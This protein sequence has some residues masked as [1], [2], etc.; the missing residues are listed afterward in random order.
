VRGYFLLGEFEAAQ[1]ALEFYFGTFFQMVLHFSG[2]DL[3]FAVVTG[4]LDFRDNF[5]S[6]FGGFVGQIRTA[7]ARTVLV[8][9]EGT[10][11]AFLAVDFGAAGALDCI[12]GEF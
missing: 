7:A 12:F 4:D 10:I 3:E 11:D 9:L 6:Y 5:A 1:P 8:L 2:F